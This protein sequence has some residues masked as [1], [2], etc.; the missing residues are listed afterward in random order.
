MYVWKTIAIDKHF[1]LQMYKYSIT[2]SMD[3]WLA[4]W[5]EK[6]FCYFLK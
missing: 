3:E 6:E 1:L 2:I 5:K 4:N